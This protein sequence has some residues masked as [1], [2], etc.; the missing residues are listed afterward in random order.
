MNYILC[1]SRALDQLYLFGAKFDASVSL[2]YTR[3]N[4]YGNEPI[5]LGNFSYII[6][7][8]QTLAGEIVNFYK[9]FQKRTDY[10]EQ[11]LEIY[12]EIV[13][14]KEFYFYFNRVYWFIKLKAPYIRISYNK[15]PLPGTNL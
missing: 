3:L 5:F 7:N 2:N 12:N 11:L 13:V 10:I 4:L 9:D 14:K 1:F 6:A 8:N 15:V